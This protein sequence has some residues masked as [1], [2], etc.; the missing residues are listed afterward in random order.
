MLCK[1]QISCI[2]VFLHLNLPDLSVTCT[3]RSLATRRRASSFMDS[4]EALKVSGLHKAS[5]CSCTALTELSSSA[6][7]GSG[8]LAALS[9]DP[10]LSLPKR[11]SPAPVPFAAEISLTKSCLPYLQV[12][13]T[14]S[15]CDQPN[16]QDRSHAPKRTPGE[17][18]K[19][20]TFCLSI[21]FQHDT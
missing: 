17:E 10:A 11:I 7:P 19:P 8:C 9:N 12:T 18:A 16:K 5:A 20:P 3:L 2:N 1:L 21:A 6:V 4:K 14:R 13:A 15:D